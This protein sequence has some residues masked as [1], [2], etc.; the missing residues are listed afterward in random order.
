MLKLPGVKKTVKCFINYIEEVPLF[1]IMYGMNFSEEIQS[2]ISLTTAA[3][4]I[5][6]V[7]IIKF[8]Y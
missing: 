7:S 3:N 5:L 8:F 6:K 2:N 4:A 1:K